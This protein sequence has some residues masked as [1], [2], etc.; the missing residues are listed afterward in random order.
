MESGRPGADSG[1]GG[2]PCARN[3]KSPKLGPCPSAGGLPVRPLAIRCG[4][5][6]GQLPFDTP[7]GQGAP[8]TIRCIKTGYAGSGAGQCFGGQGAPSTIRCIK[9][10]DEHEHRALPSYGQGAPSTIR[11]IKTWTPGSASLRQS[12][13]QGAPSTIRCIKTAH[14]INEANLLVPQSGSTQHHQVH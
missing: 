11:C 10:E 5:C 13:R 7:R 1:V 9:T 6:A 14:L 3:E 12:R 8:S 4:V 2:D